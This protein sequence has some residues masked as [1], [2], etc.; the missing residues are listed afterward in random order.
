[1]LDRT[2]RAALA[3]THSGPVPRTMYAAAMDRFG[4]PAVLTGH[5]LPVP[6]IDPGEVL[7]AVDTS[8]VGP[9]DIDVRLGRFASRKP[10]FPMVPGVDGAGIVAAVGSRVRRLKVGDQVYSYSWQNPK[11]GFYAE[12]VAVPANNVAPIPKR[13]DLQHAGAI[14]TTGLTALQGIDDALNL[15]RG[16][17]IIIHG[18]SGGVGTLAVQ[19]A[20]LRGARVFATASGIE[21]V[22]LVREMGADAVVDGKRVVDIDD[23]ARAF[24]PEG[25]DT[26]LALAGGD[27]LGQCLDALR[28]NG[29]VAHPNGIE[30]APR[31]RRGIALTRYDAVAGVRE[32]EHL[33]D[34]VQAAKLKVPIAERY[35]LA[36]A[37]KAHLR[38]EAGNVLGKIVLTVHGA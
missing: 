12:Y 4:E 14:A 33:N 10:H 21:G 37:H 30:P 19:F 18:A 3:G 13:L 15:R 35:S 38:L 34:A 11:G 6:T 1:M 17:T 22:E 26:V 27:A 23:R 36:E 25:V 9:W 31:K 2:R 7:I 16:E 20:K 32:F 8:G 5:A 28:P 29:R 24:A